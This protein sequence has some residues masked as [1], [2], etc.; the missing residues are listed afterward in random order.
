MI[1]WR[2][3]D[4]QRLI[5]VNF[6]HRSCSGETEDRGRKKAKTNPATSTHKETAPEP[7]SK[8][9][10][11]VETRDLSKEKVKRIDSGQHKKR[12]GKR[13]GNPDSEKVPIETP[14][15]SSI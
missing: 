2:A 1:T 12:S 7:K 3:L 15:D 10:S 13:P 5:S 8:K 9:R 4:S 14:W 11:S 6:A